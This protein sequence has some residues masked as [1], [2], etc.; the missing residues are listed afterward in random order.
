[1]VVALPP[2]RHV[3]L[4]RAREVVLIMP[5]PAEP[6]LR[7]TLHGH[8]AHAGEV[9]Y[10]ELVVTSNFTF[11]QGASHPEELIEQAAQL[12]YRALAIT[13]TNSLAGVVRAHVAAKQVSLPLVVGCRL[14]LS[15][16]GLDVVNTSGLHVLVYLTDLASYGRLCRLLTLGKRRAPKGEC[17][18][19]LHDLLDHH[20]GLLAVLVPPKVIDEHMVAV[21]RGLK[22]TFDRDRLSIAAAIGYHQHDADRLRQIATLCEHVGVP[23]VT[24]NDVLYHTP[25]RQPL[26]DVL[27]C[28]REGCTIEQAGLRLEPN[29]ER[30]L[31][32]PQELARLFAEH[33]HAI[34]R[35]AA[36]AERCAGF[37][38]D[39]LRYQ[40][41]HEVVPADRTS[42]QHLSELVQA[43][44]SQ[45]YPQ[46]VPAKVQAQLAHE[47]KLIAE[48]NYPHYFLT[49][50]DLIGFAQQR[51]ILC[52]GRGAAAN[53]AVC[54]CLGITAVDPERIDV[55]FERFVSK[56][57]DE[58]PDIDVDFEH[59]RREEVI[60]YLYGK[61]GRDRAALTAEVITYRGRSAVGEVGKAL[62]FSLDAVDRLSKHMGG[63]GHEALTA[64]QLKPLGFNPG[65]PT[66]QRLIQLTGELMGFPRHL[67]QHVGGFVLTDAPLCELVPIE[68]AAMADR[69]VIEWDKD[70]I[71]A[72]GMLK[73][74]V[75]GLG[76]LTAI[77]KC[78]DLV[79]QHHG[80]R[81]TL[82]SVF[83]QEPREDSAVYAMISRADTVGVF[84]I[85][86]RAQMSML[87]R[88]RP[89]CFYD[90]VIQV[91]IVRPGPIQGDMVHPYLRRRDG[92]EDVTYPDDTA[93]A[94]LG[95]T[96]GVPLFQEQVMALAVRCAGFTPGEAD[97]LRRAMAA[98]KRKGHL[99]HRFRDK[100]IQGL[101]DRGYTRDFADRCFQQIQ[102]FGEYGFPESHAASFALLVYVSAWLK[103]H[104]P[105][106]F[107][108]ALLN[109]QPMGFYGP[110]Q[111]V[112]D[113]RQH[114][115]D[116][117]PIDIHHS[118][119]DCTLEAARAPA[120]P[121]LRLGLRLV[122]GLREDEAHR[123][124]TAV[125]HHGQFHNLDTLWRTANVTTRTLRALAEADAFRSMG[126][127]RQ[128]ALWQ[129][130]KLRD[131]PAPLFERD[132]THTEPADRADA[133]PAVPPLRQVTHDYAST[134]LSLKQ[135][136][137][138][139]LRHAFDRMHVTTAD[140]L[141]DEQRWPHHT[142]IT[143]AGL[144][145]IRQRPSTARGVI[146]LTLEDETGSC[147]L[148]VRPKVYERCRVAVRTAM[149]IFVRGRVERRG[150]VVH[151]NVRSVQ[152]LTASVHNLQARSRDFH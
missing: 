65:D 100:F 58:P 9:P 21:T 80:R 61:Y 102:G 151:I 136:P 144:V 147:N 35:T 87:P 103:H 52:Q 146:F 92:L 140:E 54:Y 79:E 6:K 32:P 99:I 94:V 4:V 115:V 68:N 133:L 116:V 125:T 134:G 77:R 50:H 110:S 78:F 46:G 75:L 24:S 89:Q 26:Q 63:Y 145:T 97:A 129:V 13:D 93:R 22:Q 73:V 59:E 143:V 132:T 2:G 130:L 127:D 1:M 64:K 8:H 23:M 60:Q 39:Q 25:Q 105:A 16:E 66:V 148:V 7:P 95:K 138:H 126:L 67:S 81:L 40:Y 33:P 27:T 47:L 111:L 31:K 69:T 123:L 11:L 74:D 10:A 44:A 76:M 113:A 34:R 71:D 139:F 109:S 137:M 119:W 108:C 122:K 98:W 38:L 84:Q 131:T 72:L 112:R 56:E 90:L 141:A 19:S 20:A 57:R 85:E 88:L 70:D 124:T 82:A 106:A 104:N 117:L 120:Q 12:G 135:H 96:L 42:M 150:Q 118:Q 107:T 83:Q 142:P 15:S 17:H 49:V 55:L 152:D 18:L 114:D 28:I 5:E 91:A 41:P 30:H 37:S 101:L 48:L 149:L 36:I 53:S 43:G 86:S 3:E 51:G 14:V 29:A 62:G 45:R 121:A 128:Q